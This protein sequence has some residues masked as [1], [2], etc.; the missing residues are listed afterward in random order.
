M[1]AIN[2]I[3]RWWV[4]RAC[5]VEESDT[6]DLEHS[7]AQIVYFDLYKIPSGWVMVDR[8]D[9]IEG[10]YQVTFCSPECAVAGEDVRL[11][12]KKMEEDK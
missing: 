4:C 1:P 11:Q 6:I 12:I 10:R 5:M 8:N 9:P 2:R 3:T 7:E